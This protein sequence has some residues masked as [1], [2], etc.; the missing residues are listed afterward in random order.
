MKF[1]ERIKEIRKANKL[2]QA[3][4]A[5]MC[6]VSQGTIANW[7]AGTRS[8]DA[9]T[10]VSIATILNVTA[11]YLM[12]RDTEKSNVDAVFNDNFRM[13]PVYESVSAGFGA[14]ADDCV[15]DYMPFRIASEIEAQETI[16][17]RVKGDS[18]YPKIEDG[19]V[20]QVHK[21]DMV[22]NGEI[23]VVLIDREEGVVK[24]MFYG[25]NFIELHSINPNYPPMR[26]EGEDML[27][28]IVVGL[29]KG[30]FHEF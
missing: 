12:G 27:R 23:A 20:I 1:A 17:I 29:V 16:A 6:N 18:M 22:D 7:E 13:I 19:D 21:Q 4:L 9:E 11:D 3:K 25:E 10:I 14:Y 24:R 2:T 8:P 26:F 30:V 28:C 15:V 5:Q